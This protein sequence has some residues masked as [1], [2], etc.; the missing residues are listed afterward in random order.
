MILGWIMIGL[1]FVGMYLLMGRDIGYAKAAGV[2]AVAILATAF[3]V[4]A[5]ALISGAVG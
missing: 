4:V 5:I 3:L 1:F 2:F